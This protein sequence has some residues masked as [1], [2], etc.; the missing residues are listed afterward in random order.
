VAKEDKMRNAVL[1]KYARDSQVKTAL[2]LTVAIMTGSWLVYHV[3]PPADALP[4]GFFQL[5]GSVHD[6]QP[7]FS[8]RFMDVLDNSLQV[9]GFVNL[10][11]TVRGDFNGASQLWK[12]RFPA[13][14]TID[15]I[16]LENK[17]TGQCLADS[18]GHHPSGLAVATIRPCSDE[19]TLWQKIPQ[20]SNNVVFQRT[21]YVT[22][23]FPNIKVCPGK[24]AS[25][26]ELVITL[27]CSDGF[28][29]KMVWET[30]PVSQ[31][32]LH[33]AIS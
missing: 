22:S 8:V 4:A 13:Q 1:K 31:Q 12:E 2:V 33:G 20:G 3:V 25:N 9:S 23:P 5:R 28:T 14:G 17:H 7:P 19:A 27:V 29:N 10:H 24:D 15:V 11:S 30:T 26:R 21:T 32:Q 6:D 18:V 16:K